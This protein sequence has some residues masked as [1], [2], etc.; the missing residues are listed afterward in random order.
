MNALTTITCAQLF[1]WRVLLAAAICCAVAQFPCLKPVQARDAHVPGGPVVAVAAEL[2]QKGQ[3]SRLRLVTLGAVRP[4]VYVVSRPDRVIVDIRDM[5]FQLRG[6]DLQAGRGLVRALRYGLLGKG[7]ARIVLEMRQPVRVAAVK[8]RH[9]KDG[10]YAFDLDMQ[11]SPA[12]LTLSTLKPSAAAAAS[13]AP[14]VVVLDPGHGGLDPGAMVNRRHLEKH[15]VLQVAKRVAR[16][17]K[18]ARH[19]KVVMTRRRDRFIS[20]DQ[21][22]QKARKARGGLFVSIHADSI[23]DPKVA[24]AA[25]GA[26]VY[27]LSNRASDAAAKRFAEKENAADRLGGVLPRKVAAIQPVRNILV[28]LLKR[29]TER[30]SS[31]FRALL[32]R[33]MRARVPVARAPKRAA[34]FHVLKQTDIPAALIELGYMTNP[35]D[36]QRMR[37]KDWQERM[38]HSIAKAIIEFFRRRK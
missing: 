24:L 19:I 36:L 23:D 6:R 28:D 14:A 25:S 13:T 34:A 38:A 9:L 2:Q 22:V 10:R 3:R 5:A 37:Q 4:R 31:R 21:R 1:R 12:Q 32:V 35:L 26:S 15:I 7:Q 30:E 29:E 16:R 18:A 33:E 20:L 11:P 17:L 27:I 8:S